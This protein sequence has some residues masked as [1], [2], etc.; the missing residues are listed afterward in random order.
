MAT[1]P[2]YILTHDPPRPWFGDPPPGYDRLLNDGWLKL[3]R[4]HDLAGVSVPPPRDLLKR[5]G[6][7]ALLAV[8]ALIIALT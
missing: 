3:Y 5:F 6:H 2:S 4:R 1:P 7:G 8:S